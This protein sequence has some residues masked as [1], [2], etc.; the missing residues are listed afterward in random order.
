MLVS[1]TDP[2]HRAIDRDPDVEQPGLDLIFRSGLTNGWPML[3]PGRHALRHAGERRGRCALSCASRRYPVAGIELGEEPDG[4][5]V[6]PEDYAALYLQAAVSLHAV[7]P[8]IAL[9]GPSWQSAANDE[10]VVWPHAPGSGNDGAGLGAFSIASRRAAEIGRLGFFSFE[11][12][13]FDAC[14]SSAGPRARPRNAGRG[15][16]TAAP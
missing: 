10:M 9:G 8:K 13:P 14:A 5:R 15:A 2:W 3:R 4:Q 12:Y 11:W 1:S 16:G 6:T 7:D